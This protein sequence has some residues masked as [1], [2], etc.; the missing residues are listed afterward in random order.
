MSGSPTRAPI[1]PKS[2]EFRQRRRLH[3][4]G[5]KATPRAARWTTASTSRAAQPRSRPT[6]RCAMPP[7]HRGR[8]RRARRR[9]KHRPTQR[10]PPRVRAHPVLVSPASRAAEQAQDQDEGWQ[11]RLGEPHRSRLGVGE[12]AP[13]PPPPSASQ[14]AG[15]E[16]LPPKRC[17]STCSTRV[18]S[19][20]PRSPAS[21]RIKP[22]VVGG[23]RRD[24]PSSERRKQVAVEV[25][26]VAL[27]GPHP[28][29]ADRHHRLEALK[30]TRRHRGE[31]QPR[32]GGQQPCLRGDREPRTR[33]A[34]RVEIALDGA[35]PRAAIEHEADR[36]LAIRLPID[37]AL[38]TH[39]RPRRDILPPI[40]RAPP[41]G[42]GGHT[43]GY[44]TAPIGV[45]ALLLL[46]GAAVSDRS[47]RTRSPMGVSMRGTSGKG[48]LG[49][50]LVLWQQVGCAPFC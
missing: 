5:Y 50:A 46:A 17:T 38:D 25:V 48:I 36:V 33:A 19:W 2:R 30:P 34:R 40:H 37:A 28:P 14:S 39:P 10:R 41:R 35:K 32:A 26:A 4:A 18:G 49:R 43:N 27:Q 29:L 45:A 9:R 42:R 12:Q 21:E 3:K 1:S 7:R 47:D 24:P 44:R 20:C 16:C 11:A 31:R 13:A 23:D 15:R 8:A 6:G 22:A